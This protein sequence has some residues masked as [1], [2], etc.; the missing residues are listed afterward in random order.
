MLEK[1]SSKSLQEAQEYICESIKNSFENSITSPYK[2]TSIF[3]FQ[4]KLG[5]EEAWKSNQNIHGNATTK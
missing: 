2:D 3:F 5:S 1:A 4:D